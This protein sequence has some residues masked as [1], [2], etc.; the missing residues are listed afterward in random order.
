[1]AACFVL[2][3][4]DSL[5]AIFA[6]LKEAA[7]IHKSG[8]G[9]GF[10]FSRLRPRGDVVASTHGVSSGPI[11]FL[12]LYDLMA[13]IVRQGGRRRGANMGILRVDHPDILDFINAKRA[14]GALENFNLSVGVTGSQSLGRHVVSPHDSEA[15]PVR[16]SGCHA[17]TEQPIARQ[18]RAYK[19]GSGRERLRGGRK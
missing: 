4:E 15:Y 8:G 16:G 18:E 7:L 14:P 17:N 9:T 19:Q 12:Q 13:G 1:L 3:V 5:E 6:A 2:P 11:S 10:S